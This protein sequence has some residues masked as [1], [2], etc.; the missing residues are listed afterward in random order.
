MEYTKAIE[1]IGK[2]R[3]LIKTTLESIRELKNN[4]LDDIENEKQSLK[5]RLKG[6]DYLR[7]QIKRA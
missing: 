4:T 1:E 2:Q 6:L 3:E 5:D 7:N